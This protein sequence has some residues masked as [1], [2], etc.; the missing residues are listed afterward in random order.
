MWKFQKRPLS[1]GRHLQVRGG[2]R[3]LERPGPDHKPSQK[4]SGG[5]SFTGV[6]NI[7]YPYFT[8]GDGG[9]GDT[10]GKA[11]GQRTSRVHCSEEAR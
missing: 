9:V 7:L 6:L 2:S 4:Y 8:V 11:A 5:P 10:K 1:K 3:R